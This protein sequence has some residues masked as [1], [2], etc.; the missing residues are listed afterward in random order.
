MEALKV[1]SPRLPI[2]IYTLFTEFAQ[3]PSLRRVAGF[4]E[5]S[6]NFD[7]L[8]IK[9]EEVLRKHYP[10]RYSEK[11]LEQQDSENRWSDR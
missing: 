10:T 5:K 4:V 6:E 7:T 1:K 2:I 9:I 11:S 8:K 3:H